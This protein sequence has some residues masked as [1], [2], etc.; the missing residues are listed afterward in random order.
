MQQGNTYKGD[1][2]QPAIFRLKPYTVK[3]LCQMYDTTGNTFRRW[4]RPF[5]AE[6]GDRNG[7]YYSVLQVR[8]ILLKLG[9]PVNITLTH[10]GLEL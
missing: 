5:L 9:A 2:Q 8:T 3:E 6:I 10:A 7:R 1:E 4:L